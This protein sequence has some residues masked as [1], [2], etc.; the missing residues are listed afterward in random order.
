MF[1]NKMFKRL[2][3]ISCLSLG[4]VACQQS[5][6]FTLLNG[7]QKKLEDY[8]GQWLLINF[9]AEWCPPCLKEIPELNALAAD[10][11]QVLAVSYDKLSNHEL[12]QLKQKYQID[13][14]IIAT[15]PMPYLPME[16]PTGLPANYLFTPSGQMIGPLL[17]TQ[18]RESFLEIIEKVESSKAE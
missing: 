10:G 6:Q 7:E 11:V 18:T 2:A 3:F 1:I 12:E 5:N 9:W 17:G 16:R 13:Y 15:S 14:P 4:L 8:Q